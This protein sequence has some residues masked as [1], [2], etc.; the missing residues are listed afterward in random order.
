MFLGI[1][2]RYLGSQMNNIWAK[3]C[4]NRSSTASIVRH[5][6]SKTQKQVAV[7]NWLNNYCAFFEYYFFGIFKKIKDVLKACAAV[8]C[9]LLYKS[10]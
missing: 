7:I 3:G 8:P 10:T 9:Q 4:C 1:T 2:V 6:G 5:E